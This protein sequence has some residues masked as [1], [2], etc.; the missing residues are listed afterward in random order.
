[1]LGRPLVGTDAG[2]TGEIVSEDGGLLVGHDP[3]AIAAALERLIDDPGLRLAL[4]E[5]A[6]RHALAQHDLDASVNGHLAVILEALGWRR[7]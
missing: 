7:S 2:G 6:R 3:E 4:G 1:M 5:G